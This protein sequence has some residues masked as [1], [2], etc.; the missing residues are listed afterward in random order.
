[1]QIILLIIMVRLHL[2]IILRVVRPGIIAFDC[3]RLEMVA[4]FT[5]VPCRVGH[6]GALRVGDLV[7]TVR[8][9]EEL[10]SLFQVQ[11]YNVPCDYGWEY[12]ECVKEEMKGEFPGLLH[13]ERGW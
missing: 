7:F 11:F 10:G 4:G 5:A 8:I 2:I 13:A 1:V 6:V 9:F 12:D 3:L